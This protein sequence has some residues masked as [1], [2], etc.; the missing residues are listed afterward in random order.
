M[1]LIVVCE[2]KGYVL[3]V[4]YHLPAHTELQSVPPHFCLTLHQNRS[5]F[6][7]GLFQCGHSHFDLSSILDERA[8]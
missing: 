2:A 1:V 4:D 3:A 5:L 7:V 6:Q 8:L